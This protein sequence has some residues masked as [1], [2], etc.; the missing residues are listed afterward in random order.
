MGRFWKK[1]NEIKSKERE[2]PEILPRDEEDVLSLQ[3]LG[4]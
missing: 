2:N 1:R 3:E 4:P